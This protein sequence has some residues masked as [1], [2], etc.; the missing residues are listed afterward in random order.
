MA[1]YIK[2]TAD[3]LS[4]ELINEIG[5]ELGYK[6]WSKRDTTKEYDYPG[7]RDGNE[8]TEPADNYVE[9]HII[10]YKNLTL[11]VYKCVGHYHASSLYTLNIS[12]LKPTKNSTNQTQLSPELVEKIKAIRVKKSSQLTRAKIVCPA[13]CGCCKKS[14]PKV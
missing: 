4:N 3:M 6:M 1:L 14:T 8:H 2:P 9:G 13:D 12:T 10:P 7:A 5:E 11:L